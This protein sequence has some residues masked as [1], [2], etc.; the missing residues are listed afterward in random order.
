MQL[1]V[2]ETHFEPL[3]V[4]QKFEELPVRLIPTILEWVRESQFEAFETA[5]IP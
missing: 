3:V 5:Y 2:H 4:G 1:R